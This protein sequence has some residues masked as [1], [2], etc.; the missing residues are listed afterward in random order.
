VP[1]RSA[2]SVDRE[3]DAAES[4]RQRPAGT[5]DIGGE[6]RRDGD[7][8]A[9]CSP[10][11]GEA[12]QRGDEVGERGIGRVGFRADIAVNRER[13]IPGRVPRMGCRRTG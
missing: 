6:V 5:R 11:G 3:A 7:C 12:R 9:G 10:A 13:D 8:R 4:G 1:H 2:E